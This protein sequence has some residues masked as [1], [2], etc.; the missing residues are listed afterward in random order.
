MHSVVV[1]T[2]GRM[3]NQ[4]LRLIAPEQANKPV[5]KRGLI[6]ESVDFFRPKRCTII[7]KIT[8]DWLCA[9]AE[10][11]HPLDSL[12]LLLSALRCKKNNRRVLAR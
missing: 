11:I 12:L 5:R 6:I 10:G 9:A 1:L 8:K 2:F 7:R 3:R 4:R